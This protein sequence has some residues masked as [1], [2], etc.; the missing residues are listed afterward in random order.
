MNVSQKPWKLLELLVQMNSRY[1]SH[2]FEIVLFLWQTFQ[3]HPNHPNDSPTW[4][5]CS[6]TALMWR[7]HL[8]ILDYNDR[9]YKEV[10]VLPQRLYWEW[11]RMEGKH[12]LIRYSSSHSH[13]L[14]WCWNST[15]SMSFLLLGGKFT[16]TD[17]QAVTATQLIVI[18]VKCEPYKKCYFVRS[19]SP[20]SKIIFWHMLGFSKYLMIKW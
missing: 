12:R 19:C 16:I 10:A 2:I 9:G 20:N 18:W 4:K 11:R 7:K 5:S 3:N 6:A 8:V 17:A 13:I 1:S 14:W 15:P